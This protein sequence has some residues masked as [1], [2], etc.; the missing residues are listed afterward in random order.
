MSGAAACLAA[1]AG[2][3][4]LAPSVSAQTAG[5]GPQAWR[6][7]HPIVSVGGGW[8][9]REPLGT[10]TASTR[11][12]GLGTATPSLFTLFTAESS[13]QAARRA[14]LAIAVPV[15]RT[16]SVEVLGTSARPIL[17]TSIGRDAEGAPATTVS[18]RVE[19][20]TV[21]GRV[22]YDLPGLSIGSRARPYVVAGGAYLRQLHEDR[23]LVESG[24]VWTAGAGVRVWLRGA[25][26]GRPLGLTAEVSWHRRTGGITFK[27]SGRL[28]PSVSLRLFA[29]L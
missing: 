29:G 15:T 2:L 25:R 14:E 4:A 8:T 23:V 21:G 3:L 26:Q 16:L 10:V 18:E 24:Q 13:L 28:L 17:A 22:V 20:Y 5:S 12:T 1:L 9:S 11:A 7:W 19:D 6:P 27:D